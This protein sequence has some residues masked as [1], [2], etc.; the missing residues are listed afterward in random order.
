[1]G[2]LIRSGAAG[3]SR[4]KL[5][6]RPRRVWDFCESQFTSAGRMFVVVG[7]GVGGRNQEEF[8]SGRS[9]TVAVAVE[10]CMMRVGGVS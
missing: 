2:S 7:G 1:M 6:L 4:L 9:S 8:E 10:V 3:W 5:L